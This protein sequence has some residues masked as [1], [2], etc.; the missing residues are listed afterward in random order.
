MVEHQTAYKELKQDFFSKIRN[1][2]LRTIDFW[3]KTTYKTMHLIYRLK[4]YSVY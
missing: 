1:I 2:E 4:R 3:N